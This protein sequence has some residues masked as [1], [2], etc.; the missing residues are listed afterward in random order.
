MYDMTL[1]LDY[2]SLYESLK[3]KINTEAFGRAVT[4][5]I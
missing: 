2:L 1:Y 5:G 4:S 3:L